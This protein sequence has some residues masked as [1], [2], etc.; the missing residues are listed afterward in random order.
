MPHNSPCAPALGDS[1]SAGMPVSSTSQRAST[2]IS[3][4]APLTVDKRLQRMDVGEAGKP[5]HLLVEAR[6]VLHGARAE[7]IDA[8]VDA[9]VR[10]RQ[11][12]V[13]AHR[14]GLAQ[15]RQADRRGSLERAQA[16]RESLRLVEIDAAHLR[17]ADLEDQRLLDAQRAVAGEGVRRAVATASPGSVGRPSRFSIASTSLN[18]VDERVAIR[19]GVHL[20]RGHD[21]QSPQAP[22]GSGSSREN[23]TP[24]STPFCARLLDQLRRIPRHAGS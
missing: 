9:V 17:P 14:L 4:S 22:G 24:P 21:D 16:G 6:I 1:A 18:A 13:V 20:G 7:R 10:A 19:L 12:H 5:R 2:W 23:G 8:G 11:A 15:A 3:S